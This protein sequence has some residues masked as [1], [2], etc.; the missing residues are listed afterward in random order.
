MKFPSIKDI[1]YAFTLSKTEENDI[2]SEIYLNKIISTKKNNQNF[3]G[4]NEYKIY[5]LEK[6]KSILEMNNF[7][8]EIIEKINTNIIMPKVWESV[9]LFKS[10]MKLI[11]KKRKNPVNNENRINE[12][13]EDKKKGRISLEK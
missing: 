9:Y 4:N 2:D 11:G 7:P 10:K 5:T 3:S 1:Q 12:E 6:I 13:I 8:E